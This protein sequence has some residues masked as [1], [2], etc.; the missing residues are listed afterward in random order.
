MEQ[1]K[2]GIWF[3]VVNILI[4]AVVLIFIIQNWGKVTFNFLGLKLEGF[5]FLVFLVIFVLGFLTG[6]LWAYFR[7]RRNKSKGRT[8]DDVHYLEE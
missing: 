7:G 8:S 2:R 5:G 4:A 6:W 3:W 1:K